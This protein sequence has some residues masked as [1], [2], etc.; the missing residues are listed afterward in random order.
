MCNTIHASWRVAD[1][2]A[3]HHPVISIILAYFSLNL[4]NNCF[5]LTIAI[6]EEMVVERDGKR[7]TEQSFSSSF[8]CLHPFDLRVGITLIEEHVVKVDFNESPLIAHWTNNIVVIA[9]RDFER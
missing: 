1:S 9:T 7:T 4:T 2:R 5:I 8:K 3:S 6:L